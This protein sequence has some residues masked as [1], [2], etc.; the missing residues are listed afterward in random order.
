MALT[1]VCAI[2]EQDLNTAHYL[3][4]SITKTE[5]DF[6][7][8]HFLYYLILLAFSLAITQ[9]NS[10]LLLNVLPSMLVNKAFKHVLNSKQ[11]IKGH[12]AKLTST[13]HFFSL[14]GALHHFKSCISFQ[15]KV[16]QPQKSIHSAPSVC[17]CH[18][19]PSTGKSRDTHRKHSPSPFPLRTAKS[20]KMHNLAEQF[21]L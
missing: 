4:V 2:R 1:C 11:I 5:I 21:Y 15:H 7:F 16:P 19:A 13:P 18:S 9:F 17:I 20:K 6:F 12:S 3:L 14:K 8:S 10:N